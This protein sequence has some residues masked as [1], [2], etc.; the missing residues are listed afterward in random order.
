[1][2]KAILLAASIALTSFG[3]YAEETAPSF[4]YELISYSD[5]TGSGVKL[6]KEDFPNGVFVTSV[7]GW[8][9]H[10]RKLQTCLKQICVKKES[11]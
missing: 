5:T 4:E 11:R 7:G 1:M 8:R 9:P 6:T 3:T 10:I 2:F